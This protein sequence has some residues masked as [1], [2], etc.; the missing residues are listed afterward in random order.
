MQIF[1][2]IP[3]MV[4]SLPNMAWLLQK[5]QNTHACTTIAKNGTPPI[6]VRIPP[7]DANFFTDSKSD[8]PIA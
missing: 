6:F 1:S 4:S 7:L 2:L 5:M 8:I 3:N